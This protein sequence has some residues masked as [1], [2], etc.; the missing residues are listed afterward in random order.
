MAAMVFASREVD[1]VRLSSTSVRC[2]SVQRWGPTALPARFT[3]AA[4][5]SRAPASI[6]PAAG[7]QA[8]VSVPGLGWVPGRTSRRTCRPRCCRAATRAEPIRPLAPPTTTSPAATST[9]QVGCSSRLVRMVALQGLPACDPGG[10]APT[11][12]GAGPPPP[13]KVL[14]AAATRKGPEL[15]AGRKQTQQPEQYSD[16]AH[17]TG[18]GQRG[19]ARE[20]HRLQTGGVVDGQGGAAGT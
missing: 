13:S 4:A 5:P 8:M 2:A 1:R 3:T 16:E 12:G 20:G 6:V 7:S 14:V 18:A 11:P 10:A 9:S 17:V 15:R 19:L